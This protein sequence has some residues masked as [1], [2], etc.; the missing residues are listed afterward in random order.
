MNPAWGRLGSGV[1]YESRQAWTA[2]ANRPL[3]PNAWPFRARDSGL[4]VER[5]TDLED[6][7]KFSHELSRT[8]CPTSR[9]WLRNGQEPER[10]TQIRRAVTVILAATL[11]SRIRQVQA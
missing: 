2:G 7:E 5:L 8:A 1:E 3:S 6:E 11:M 4:M 9:K 10:K